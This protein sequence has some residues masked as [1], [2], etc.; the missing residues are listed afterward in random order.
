MTSESSRVE[1]A[2]LG[3]AGA[4]EE[5]AVEYRPLAYRTARSILGEGAAADDVTQDAMVRLHTSLPGFRGE[6]DL[7][8]WL[9]RVTL[10]LAY[11][12]IRRTRRAAR[13][14]PLDRADAEPEPS[15]DPHRSV[16]RERAHAALT[17][18]LGR[19]PKEQGEAV[20]LRF[21][22][23]LSYREIA[24]VL[25]LPEGTVASRI[26]RALARLGSDLEP[27]HLEILR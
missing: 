4:L 11:D 2:V 1:R 6:A 21:L 22:S 3:D 15:T 23:G 10:N 26:Y 27:K 24:T 18:A 8:T 13:E 17:D 20:R 9:Y 5:L 7:G 12:H 25:S 19:L 14:V 16:D